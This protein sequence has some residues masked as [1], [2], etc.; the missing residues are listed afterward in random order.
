MDFTK[1]TA[2]LDSLTEKGIPSVDMIVY[3]D[4]EPLYRHMAGWK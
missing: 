3:R 1:L 4:H 2:Y